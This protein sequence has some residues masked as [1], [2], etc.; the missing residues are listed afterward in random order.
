MNDDCNG[1][2]N[3]CDESEFVPKHQGPVSPSSVVIERGDLF[4]VTRG[5]VRPITPFASQQDH[6]YD[7]LIFEAMEVCAEICAARVVYPSD[8]AAFGGSPASINL[9]ELCTMTVSRMFLNRLLETEKSFR[10]AAAAAA[11]EAA[12]QLKSL[13]DSP[14]VQAA[15]QGGAMQ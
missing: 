9:G 3:K 7:G 13:G 10:A 15:I 11:K 12:E 1:T 8:P 5:V 2:C 14:I 4:V 6:S